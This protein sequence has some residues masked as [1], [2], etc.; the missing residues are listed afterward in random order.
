MDYKDLR[1][2]PYGDQDACDAIL[3]SLE[4]RWSKADQDVFIAAVLLNPFFK[5]RPFKPLPRFQPAN[6]H[7]LFVRL[8]TWFFPGEAV[9]PTLYYNVLH[10]LRETGDFQS[11]QDC[12]TS[13]LRVSE[14]M[15]HSHSQNG[16]PL[17][18]IIPGKIP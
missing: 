18:T 7:H 5:H 4:K 10:Y 12:A 6:I 8:W 2:K 14:Q 13:C 1:N 15:V 16:H 9:P 17:L 11:L 3:D